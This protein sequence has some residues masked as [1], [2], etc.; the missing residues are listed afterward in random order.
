MELSLWSSWDTF[1]GAIVGTALVYFF[2]IL[3]VRIA[4]RRTLARI[5][6]Y[7]VVVTVAVGTLAASTALPSD[8]S[9]ADGAAVLVTFLA[10]QILIG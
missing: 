1:T 5:S 7:D 9:L 2:T 4:G 8:P 6:G 3:V 10:L